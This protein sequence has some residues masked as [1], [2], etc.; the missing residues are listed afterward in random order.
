VH[1]QGSLW[2]TLV[3]VAAIAIAAAFLVTG[4]HEF[5]KERIVANERA[6]LLA[7]LNSVLDPELVDEQLNPV[8]LTVTDPLLGSREPVAAFIPTEAGRPVAVILAPI[9]P[10]GYN[11]A[12]QLLIGITVD[13]TIMGVRAV[14]HRETPGL[15]DAIDIAKSD[16]IR[17]FD[18]KS[19]GDPPLELWAV[20]KDDGAF[21]SITGATVTPRAVVKA[22]RNTLL[23]FD[24]HKD[25]LFAQAAAAAQEDATQ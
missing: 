14:S 20:D 19:L 25:E 6:R 16:W 7:S 4:S 23:Y 18:A 13:G 12:I 2:R 8:A 24:A 22:I 9:A 17:Q 10:D 11:A 5:S 15:G 1:E 21:D 3:F